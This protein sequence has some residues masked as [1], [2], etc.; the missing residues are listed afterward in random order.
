[1][2]KISQINWD[3]LKGI[4]STAG[5]GAGLGAGLGGLT[6][7]MAPNDP[8][9]PEQKHRSI[10][11]SMLLGGS[12]GG[13]AFGGGRAFADRVYPEL[14]KDPTSGMSRLFNPPP[15]VPEKPVATQVLSGLS[16]SPP[17][18]GAGL[19][20][21]AAGISYKLNKMKIEGAKGKVESA[22]DILNSAKDTGTGLPE[23]QK[24]YDE[25]LLARDRVVSPGFWRKPSTHGLGVLG[26]TTALGYGMRPLLQTQEGYNEVNQDANTLG[27]QTLPHP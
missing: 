27:E 4:G 7:A 15:P 1:M 21:T 22:K 25:R 2:N 9:D 26:L 3:L 10:L 17:L 6:S 24:A 5:V 11:K 23:A 16:W 20:G 12:L 13:L 19:G 14:S 8:D 18:A